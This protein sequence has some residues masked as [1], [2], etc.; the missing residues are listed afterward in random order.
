MSKNYDEVFEHF[1]KN[2][3]KEIKFRNLLGKG[4]FG[5]VRECLIGNNIYA[6]KLVER[7]KSGKIDPEKLRGKN[8]IEI[9]KISQSKFGD[10][11]YDLIIM[12]NALLKDTKTFITNLFNFKLL[13]TINYPFDE[14]VGNNILRFLTRQ[15]VNGMETLERN[16]LVHFDI[17]PENILITSELN[18]KIS[19]FS[20]LKD[21]NQ[22]NDELI[23]PGGTKGYVP[24]EYYENKKV[25]INLAKKHDYFALGATLFFLKFNKPL[26]KY[27]DNL[28][29]EN[30]NIHV[31]NLLQKSISL[32]K[33]NLLL[34][35]DFIS[36][37][38]SLIDY[39]P[40]ERPDFED[41][42]RNKWLNENR[43]EIKEITNSYYQNDERKLIMELIKSDFLIEKKKQNKNIKKSRFK[44]VK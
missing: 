21:L 34:D 42:Y 22:E 9:M 20:F 26:L 19:D 3:E 27:K 33:S 2:Y 23:T 44:F 29:N 24:P 17:K 30:A 36:F 5:K 15:I 28:S 37:L 31:I 4:A 7:E 10:K 11:Y 25:K 32:L 8:I 39:L 6:A 13:K 12:E 1:R 18:I 38:S 40:E 43:E 41:I 14:I 16:E 35:K